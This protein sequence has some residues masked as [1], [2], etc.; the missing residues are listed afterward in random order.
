[1]NVDHSRVHGLDKTSQYLTDITVLCEIGRAE[2]SSHQSMLWNS[3]IDRY[4]E[5][6][7]FVSYIHEALKFDEIC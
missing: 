5:R 1:M 4:Y 3:L 6:E 2:L 7:G